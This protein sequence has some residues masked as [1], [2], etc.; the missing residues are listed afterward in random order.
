MRAKYYQS[1]FSYAQNKKK[2]MFKSLKSLSVPVKQHLLN[3][4]MTIKGKRWKFQSNK[5]CWFRHVGSDFFLLFSQKS[6][7]RVF[8]YFFSKFP[9]V[10]KRAGRTGF[11]RIDRLINWRLVSQKIFYIKPKIIEITLSSGTGS[12]EKIGIYSFLNHN[13][14][15]F[16]RV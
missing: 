16:I 5:N 11:G 2:I 12:M 14:R 1:N 13:R 6:I 15:S 10:D 9:L 8:L 4:S 3:I 7:V